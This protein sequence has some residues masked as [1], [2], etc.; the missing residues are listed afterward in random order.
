MSENNGS[1]ASKATS[2]ISSPTILPFDPATNSIEPDIANVANRLVEPYARVV[3][4]RTSLL[5]VEPTLQPARDNR[6][7]AERGH[8]NQFQLRVRP[9]DLIISLTC[10]WITL[11]RVVVQ[12]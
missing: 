10:D 7:E 9:W 11:R 3:D 4:V 5:A 6:P 1:Q 2:P 12:C 8:S